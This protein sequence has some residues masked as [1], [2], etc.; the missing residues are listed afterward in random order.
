M[1][2]SMLARESEMATKKKYSRREGWKKSEKDRV[3]KDSGK[4]KRRV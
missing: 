2:L 3:K 4:S 1:S